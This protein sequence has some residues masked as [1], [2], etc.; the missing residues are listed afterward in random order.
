MARLKLLLCLFS[1]VIL[2]WK[3]KDQWDEHT[4]LNNDVV[5]EDI[6]EVI[7][8]KPELSQFAECLISTGWDKELSSSK[9]YTLWAPNNEAM[10]L[11][12]ETILNDS[13]KLHQF[14]ANHIGFTLYSYSSSPS[15]EIKKIKTFSGKNIKIDILNGKVEDASL[16]QPFDL[17]ANNGILHI[18]DKPLIPKQNI[19]EYI[20][21]TN[22]C[23]K[24][25]GYLNSLTGMVFDPTVATQIGIHPVT[26]KPVYDTLSGMVW[27]NYFIYNVRDLR[28]E[29]SIFTIILI[30]DEVF[31]QEFSKF[32][33][34]YEL[35]TAEST[36]SLTYWEICKDLVFSGQYDLTSIPDTLFSIY[37]V[38]IPFN[39]TAI[40]NSIEASNG[41]IYILNNC[42]VSLKDKI[43]RV[44]IEGE[45]TTKYITRSL[46][47]Q[48][49]YTRQKELAS[50]GYDFILDNHGAN[51]GAI[52]YHVGKVCA[53]QYKFY[54]KAVND[55]DASYRYPDTGLLL[56]QKLERVKVI[57]SMG[58]TPVFS[59][60][61]PI[62][63]LIPVNDSTYTTATE[64]FL[65][66]Y[67]FVTY[68]DLWLQITGGGNNMSITLDYLKIVPVF[69]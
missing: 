56:Q 35:S 46:V 41:L 31:D 9:S 33:K 66:Q 22:V 67:T 21:N 14:V 51:P 26:G 2:F 32:R 23:P 16:V 68:Q 15:S 48:T 1:I 18:I 11:V 6:M 57:G 61:S 27:S 28:N 59:T 50:G 53:T 47:G 24:H 13:A 45:D 58:E 49:G 30:T 37:N 3:C 40:E 4:K 20:E 17:L 8:D 62:S 10:T 19:W 12:D 7:N 39:Q 34:Y 65:G 44:I 43:Q 29:D 52:Q 5:Q 60:P 55:F 25:A 63:N 38:K 64:V 42:D 36:D 69:E 54:W